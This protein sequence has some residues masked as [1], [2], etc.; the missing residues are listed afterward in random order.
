[1]KK[2]I[3]DKAF[4]KMVLLIAVPIMVQNGLTTFVSLLDNIMVGQVGTNEMSGVA[5]VNQLIM[6]F[7]VTIFGGM[8][9][10]GIFTAQYYGSGDEDGVRYTVRLK[11]AVALV[12][13]ALWFVIFGFRGDSLIQLFIHGESSGTDAAA[14]FEYAST[15]LKMMMAGLIPYAF[16]QAYG[17]TLRETGETVVPMKA[18]M[19]AL[20]VN[21]VLDYGLI[22]GKFGLPKMG[23]FGAALA[24]VLARLAECAVVI[25]WTHTHLEQRPFMRHLYA[26]MHVP[27]SMI[28]DVVKKGT[29]LLLNEAMWSG[30]MAVLTQCYST[31]GL[32]VIAGINIAGTVSNFF[33]VVYLAMGSAIAI[34]VGQL[35]GAGKME[36]AVDT[37]R[38]LIFFSVA[39]CAVMAVLM[40][41]IAAPFF[42][43]IYNTTAEVKQIA[44]HIIWVL[45]FIMP[46]NAFIHA[47]YFT[48][49]SGGKTIITFFF[50]SFYLWVV[51]VTAAF[52]QTHYTDWNIV[53]IYFLVQL[54]EFIKCGIGYVLVKKG[55]WLNN[56]TQT[57]S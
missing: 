28:K 27:T 36:E 48:L 32:A 13:I 47:T 42:P 23:V 10:V 22:F 3:G 18:G 11:I 2:F 1:M 21:L 49:R 15:Y 38:K 26:S 6:V 17:A 50:D 52:L 5:I 24:T 57:A 35:L 34:I 55:V 4:Y 37:D 54:F 44:K 16:T 29:P 33:S 19:V 51:D 25:I 39:S 14:T 7:N 31:R 43:Q 40:A 30:G 45:A 53:L 56:M 46:V 9:G 20:V 12:L 8:S 41:V